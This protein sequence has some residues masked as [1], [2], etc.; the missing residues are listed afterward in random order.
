MMNRRAD[1]I[2]RRTWVLLFILVSVTAC[3]T[4]APESFHDPQMDF[5]ALRTVAVMPFMNLTNDKL[6]GERVRDTF[7]TSLLSTGVVYVI[8]SGEVARG[9]SR[10]AMANPA[11]PSAED[12]AKLTAMMQADAVITGVV[13]EYGEVRSGQASAGVI[14]VSMQM[15]EKETRKVVWTAATTKG[16]ISTW[17]RLFG[18]GGRPMNE[19]TEQAV[20][21]IITK[22]LY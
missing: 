18:A 16:G 15:I 14:S 13:R 21:E 3:A 19:L 12:I 20:N 4:S 7:M 8:P 9:I 5:A 17:D 22:L 1:S 6:A 10:V 2:N 11:D